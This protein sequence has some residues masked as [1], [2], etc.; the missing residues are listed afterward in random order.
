MQQ[1]NRR[2]SDS[3]DKPKALKAQQ[4]PRLVCLDG[5]QQKHGLGSNQN[6]GH[7]WLE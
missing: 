4:S 1:G 5:M 6:N 7:E 2:Q 3:G